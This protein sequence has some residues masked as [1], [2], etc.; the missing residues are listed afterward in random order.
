MLKKKLSK[1]S[2]K[3]S[4]SSLENNNTIEKVPRTSSK[5]LLKKL[6]IHSE[7]HCADKKRDESKNSRN[8]SPLDPVSPVDSNGSTN[9]GSISPSNRTPRS[10]SKSNKILF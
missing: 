10:L 5:S 8:I 2:F 3:K 6:S 4:R 9:P 1:I 7:G